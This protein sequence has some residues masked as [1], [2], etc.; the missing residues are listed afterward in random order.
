MEFLKSRVYCIVKLIPWSEVDL[1]HLY[2][3]GTKLGHFGHSG[4]HCLT[5]EAQNVAYTWDSGDLKMTFFC[6]ASWALISVKKTTEHFSF[7]KLSQAFIKKLPK[8]SNM[9]PLWPKIRIHRQ[10]RVQFA[11][12]NPTKK[13]SIPKNTSHCADAIEVSQYYI[14]TI[15]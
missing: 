12:Q 7:L 3:F 1:S 10:Y 8:I 11:L 13:D 15:F 6:F 4:T 5:A 9:W 14:T 2:D